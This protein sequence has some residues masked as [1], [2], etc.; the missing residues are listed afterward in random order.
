[1]VETRFRRSKVVSPCTKSSMMMPPRRWII[2]FFRSILYLKNSRVCRC[3][4]TPPHGSATSPSGDR[5]RE[6]WARAHDVSAE[7]LPAKVGDGPF[8]P[9]T[10]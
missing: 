4:P 7:D 6:R 9:S 5:A 1:M 3:T 8:D 10:I 2:G